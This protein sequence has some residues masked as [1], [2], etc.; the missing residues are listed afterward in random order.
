MEAAL[1][2]SCCFFFLLLL[3]LLLLERRQLRLGGSSRHFLR[4]GRCLRHNGRGLWVRQPVQPGLRHEHGG[5]EHGALQQ[6]AQLRVVLRDAVRH[7]PEVVHRR[8]LH[9]RHRDQ[10]LPP[11][12]RPPQRQRRLVQPS[13]QHFD[14]AEPAFLHR[15]VP[16]RNRP[17]LLPQGALYEEGGNPVHRERALLLQPGAD[18]QRG[19]GRRRARGVHQGV[20][21][22][23]A[24]DVP[25][26]GPELAEQLVPQRAEPVVP[27]DGERRE[28]RHRVQRRPPV[29]SSARP[30]KEANS[31]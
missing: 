26:L 18:Q 29:G 17:R 25:Q 19:R 7:R 6:R 16:C 4:R 9:R 1:F 15:P 14:L 28:D 30:S 8:R 5:A 10:L 31:R 11:Q 2:N 24:G 3:L 21:G 20:G 13:L 23:V 27:G 12:L 22:R